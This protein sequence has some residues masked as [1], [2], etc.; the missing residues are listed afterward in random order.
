MKVSDAMIIEE[1]KPKNGTVK[2]GEDDDEE[3]GNH[4]DPE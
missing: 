1:F 4:D 3:D 2:T